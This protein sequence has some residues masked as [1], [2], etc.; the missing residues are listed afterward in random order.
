MQPVRNSAFS[1]APALAL[2]LRA[3]PLSAGEAGPPFVVKIHADW[4]G[5]CV[6]LPPTFEA[7]EKELDGDA[8]LVV[9]DVTDAQTAE[10]SRAEA[11]RLGVEA[12]Y[13]EY[14]G[15]TGTVGVLDASGRPVAV[16]KG[17]TQVAKYLVALAKA[18]Q[19][20]AP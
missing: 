12:S 5:T 3:A 14:R 1:F 11:E 20:P 10:R 13:E 6:R 4:C 15:R 16:L 19:A 9:L 8:R 7:L 2:L 17:A 18:R